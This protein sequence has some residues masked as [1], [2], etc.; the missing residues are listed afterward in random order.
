MRAMRNVAIAVAAVLVIGVATGCNPRAGIPD[1]GSITGMFVSNA[2]GGG[3]LPAVTST[4]EGQI[5]YTLGGHRIYQPDFLINTSSDAQLR[6]DAAHK[7]T[8]YISVHSPTDPINCTWSCFAFQTGLMN[9]LAQQL[10]TYSHPIVFVLDHEPDVGNNPHGTPQ[11]YSAMEANMFHAIRQYAPAVST[12][13]TFGYY[14]LW[15]GQLTQSQYSQYLPSDL[16][17]LDIMGVDAYNDASTPANSQSLQSLMAP[18]VTF[19]ANENKPV[20]IFE[21][22]TKL[23]AG[24]KPQWMQN[25]MAYV[26]SQP[27]IKGI[28][29]FHANTNAVDPV[30]DYWIDGNGTDGQSLNAYKAATSDPYFIKGG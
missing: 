1:T 12:A 21:V 8:S 16:T 7:R 28:L 6:D 20:T 5:G 4:M 18:W 29:W 2:R 19:A 26:K 22:G 13:I 23:A 14:K 17:L 11:G 3:S 9:Q 24:S 15:S 10:A 25:A 27:Q 30:N